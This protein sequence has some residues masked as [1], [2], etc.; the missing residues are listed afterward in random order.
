M[1]R[2]ALIA[3]VVAAVAAGAFLLHGRAVP[4]DMVDEPAPKRVERLGE[5]ITNSLSDIPELSTQRL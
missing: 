3:L 5:S 2:A 1:K 4:A